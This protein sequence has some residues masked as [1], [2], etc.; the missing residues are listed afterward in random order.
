MK[1]AFATL[2]I[3]LSFTVN[4]DSDT[5]QIIESKDG[6]VI[7]LNKNTGDMHLVDGKGLIALTENTIVL[8]KGHYYEMG[9]GKKDAKY[10]K[11]LGNGKFEKSKFAIRQVK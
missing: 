9:D 8:K 5:F 7:R 10:L 2:L 1:I 4:A 6:R 3:F 11:Y